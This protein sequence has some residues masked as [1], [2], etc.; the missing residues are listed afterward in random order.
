MSAIMSSDLAEYLDAITRDKS[1]RVV[2]TLKESPT[3]KTQRV[4]FTD[5]DGVEYGPYVRKYIDKETGLG[6][7]Y[8]RIMKAQ[9]EGFELHFLPDIID[10]YEMDSWRVVIMDD[11]D[12]ET[13][14]DYVYRCDPSIDL[15]IEIFPQLCDAVGELHMKFEPPIIHRDLKPSNIMIADGR[16]IIIDFGIARTFKEESDSDTLHFGTRAYA[17]PEQFGFGQTDVRS[18]VYALG[19]LLY[20]CLTEKNPDHYARD[21]DFKVKGVSE[22][23]SAVIAR[24]TALDPSQRYA[25]AAELKDAFKAACTND[26]SGDVAEHEYAS[27]GAPPTLSESPAMDLPE[28]SRQADSTHEARKSRPHREPT[29]K[30]G[31]LLARIPFPL[32]VLWDIILAIVLVIILCACLALIF[33]P[34]TGSNPSLAGLTLPFRILRYGC[35]FLLIGAIAYA[36]CDRRPL[37]RFAPRLAHVTVLQETVVCFV[38]IV[39]AAFGIYFS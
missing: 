18:D 13:L 31:R 26:A 8:E 25:S 4:M 9:K 37:M 12:G 34:D 36:V 28:S 1:Y 30:V 35:A 17:P 14:S 38:V 29:G 3:E 7:V 33:D 16:P 32:G 21:S 20:F 27:D 2:T 5:T 6:T 24:A 11:V 15:A 22:G 23:L 39:L 19:M 10:C